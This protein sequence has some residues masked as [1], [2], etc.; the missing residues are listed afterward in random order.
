MQVSRLW[1]S[2]ALRWCEANQNLTLSM[3]PRASRR[4]GL[5]WQRPSAPLSVPA[6]A[7]TIKALG[8]EGRRGARGV[9]STPRVL[10]CLF[11]GSRF[12]VACHGATAPQRRVTTTG[13]PF[14]RSR[15]T[16][17]SNV[18]THQPVPCPIIP[19]LKQPFDFG[20]QPLSTIDSTS[21]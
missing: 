19:G 14:Q 10:S 6:E 5:L 20:N 13:S 1:L 11:W 12:Q 18:H 21:P 16:F 4:S 9:D 7:F 17:P 2:E 3:S 8:E 15:P